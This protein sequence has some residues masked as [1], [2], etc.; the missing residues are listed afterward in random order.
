MKKLLSLVVLLLASL[1]LG[2]QEQDPFSAGT[3]NAFV[4]SAPP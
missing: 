1:S 4:P 3:F 2:A